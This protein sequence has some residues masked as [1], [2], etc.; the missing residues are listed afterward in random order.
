MAREYDY[1][2][3]FEFQTNEILEEANSIRTLISGENELKFDGRFGHGEWFRF[4]HKDVHFDNAIRNID[5]GLLPN[6]ANTIECAAN[7]IGF[8]CRKCEANV[9]DALLCLWIK[10]EID[11]A[12]RQC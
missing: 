3:H 6:F 1:Y 12:H 10:A 5:V 4:I 9:I 2:Y 7:F 11:F 8:W